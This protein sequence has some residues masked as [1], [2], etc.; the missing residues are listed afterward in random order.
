MTP[1]YH[2]AILLLAAKETRFSSAGSQTVV[3]LSQPS[4]RL[5]RISFYH[6]SLA[7][8]SPACMLKTLSALRYLS[9]CSVIAVTMVSCQRSTHVV[10]VSP[11]VS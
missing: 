11:N 9:F 7:Q 10:V 1:F 3:S 8:I 6:A 2:R 5:A 4:P